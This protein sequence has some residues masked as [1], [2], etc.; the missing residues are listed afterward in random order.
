MGVP[1]TQG[2]A[3]TGPLRSLAPTLLLFFFSG[4]TSLV[5]EVLW[6]RRLGLV[7]GATQLAVATVLGA[8]MLGLA[9]GAA[10]AGRWADRRSNLLQ[11]YALLEF[12]IGLY[13]LA[14]PVLLRGLTA[15]YVALVGSDGDM[16]FWPLQL[17]QL[18][19]VLVLLAPPTAA[20][21]ATLPLLV[22]FVTDRIS[23]AAMR[24]G[25]L[26]GVNT[27]GA[28]VGVLS[29]GFILLPAFGTRSTEVGAGV[30]N[31][32]IGVAA[33]AW[34]ARFARQHDDNVSD[35]DQG[36]GVVDDT[37]DW[38]EAE[39]LLELEPDPDQEGVYGSRL[40]RLTPIVLF[41]SGASAMVYEVGWTRFLA[42]VLGSSVYAFTLMLVVFLGGTA[43]GALIGAR[44]VGRPG[45]RPARW[46][47]GALAGA[48]LAGFG[49]HHLFRFMPYWYVDL[50]DLLGGHVVA[51]FGGQ[52]LLAVIVMAPATLCLGSVF[53]FAVKLG[54][55]RSGHLGADVARLYVSN[56][57][58]AVTGALLG[59]F[60]LLPIVG[61]QDSLM[62]SVLGL[63]ALA[64]LVF[65]GRDITRRK[66]QVGLVALGAL[67]LAAV[68]L[69]APWDP[70]LM[71]A[72]MYQ[73]VSE[74]S[75][76][77][78]ESV[79]NHAISDFDVLFYEEGTTSVVTVAR[80]RGSGNLWLAN[81]G[82]VDA[83]TQEDLRTQLLLAH[84]PYFHREAAEDVLVIG[85]ASG[86]TA[87][88]VTLQPGLE[89]LDI[90]EIEPKV[91]EASRLF[92]E[93]NR[94]PLEDPR[95][96]AIA[97]DA[98]N[99]LVLRAQPYD[100]IV[101]EPSNPWISGVSNL[102]TR[103]FLELGLSRLTQS[104][105]FVQ[106]VQTYGMARDDFR[107]VLRTFC[108][109]FPYAVLYF[110]V[111]DAD[112]ILLGSREP[113]PWVTSLVDAALQDAPR[114]QDLARIGVQTA[115][116]PLSYLVLGKDEMMD[117]AWQAVPNTDDN[118][119]LEFNSPLYLDHLTHDANTAM[120]LDA[121][122]P[123]ADHFALR[124]EPGASSADLFQ[125]LGRSFERTGRWSE[126]AECY[127]RAARQEP[128]RPG[129]A[130]ALARVR[131]QLVEAR[132]AAR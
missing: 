1:M 113:L 58:G 114:A 7:F 118:A 14:F 6:M 78:H 61:I 91:I 132:E 72:G 74:L 15:V 12:A 80:S 39:E 26:Y 93:H 46:L 4:A 66:R 37:E 50:Y 104:G 20:M 107:S 68:G 77:S 5:Y 33:L 2:S 84:L 115:Y 48:G 57:L 71:S 111:E 27:V 54:A 116:D 51:M 36:L 129:L 47:V 108:E 87:G 59:G 22:R 95:V 99:H 13:A 10:F 89:S 82:K 96:R 88:S 43:L 122:P 62:V 40:A 24:T 11:V 119:R 21:G 52:A 19:L 130:E 90:L 121:R 109:V 120:I 34:S 69:R 35:V 38:M 76:Y 105:V 79:R 110:T 102:F 81:N 67:S 125:G 101:S 98:R 23:T 83:S 53:P 42:L 3:S 17:T 106:W 65:L 28:T 92:D 127:I 117:I 94:R 44:W 70:L 16:G 100:L 32:A 75:D 29:A 31:L 30:F 63:L 9:L 64:T 124:T 112:A 8:F 45:A 123:L 55:R 41:G 56:T 85:L 86:I 18:A 49:T 126:A 128:E 25:L 73:Y 60:V 131:D 103:E 97:R